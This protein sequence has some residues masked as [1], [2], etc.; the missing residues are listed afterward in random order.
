[1][2]Q[3]FCLGWIAGISL[4]GKTWGDLQ[5][6]L[7][8]VGCIAAVWLVLQRMMQP[9]LKDQHLALKIFNICM[10]I[11]LAGYLGF[12]YA[13][14]ALEQ[15]LSH[16]EHQPEDRDVIVYVE[17]LSELTEQGMQQKVT[18]LNQPNTASS[19]DQLQYLAYIPY[20]NLRSQQQELQLGQYYRLQGEL[21]PA[22]S[23]AIGGAFDQEKWYLQQRIASGFRVKHMEAL[24]EQHISALGYAK[25]IEQHQRWIHQVPLWI[26][27]QRLNFRIFLQHQPLPNKGL[28]LALLTGDESLLS[29]DTKMQFQQFGMSHLLAISGPHVVIFAMMVSWLLQRLIARF[30]PQQYLMIPK[31][32]ALMAPFLSCVFLY[33][34]FAGF[35]IPAVR[36]LLMCSLGCVIL[37]IQQKLQ[38]MKLLLLSAAI[39]LLIDPFS[40]LSAAFWLSYGACFILLRIYQTL[41]K[42]QLQLPQEV[43]WKKKLALSVQLLLESQWKIFAAL[44]PL[45]ILFFKQLAWITP[46]SNIIAIPWLGMLV[47]PLDIL[48]AMSYSISEPL[49]A[50]LFLLNDRLLALLLA[51]LN[52]LDFLFKPELSAI[53]MNQPMLALLAL[54]LLI[55][56]LPRRLLPKGWAVIGLLALCLKGFMPHP[57]ELTVLDV[58]QGQAIFIRDAKRSM[59]VDMGGNYDES[60]FSVGKQIILP[61]LAVNAVSEL[62]QLVLTH[63]DQDHSGGY[64]S[65]QNQLA[66]HQLISSERPESLPV[67]TQFDY[68]T[69]GQHWQWENQVSIEVLS[70]LRE[71]LQRQSQSKNENSCVLYVQIKQAAP[72]QSFLL[73]GDA[74]WET[75]FQLLQHYPNLHADVLVLGHHGSQHSSAY[76]FL[77]ALQPKLAIASAGRFNRYGHPSKL[78]QARL[79]QLNIPLLTTSQQGSIQFLQQDGKIRINFAR[80]EWK[81]LQKIKAQEPWPELR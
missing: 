21:R 62:D 6:S 70:P 59:M 48:A 19:D 23:Y 18:V 80:D 41:Q 47:V 58:G 12:G 55:A 33:C 37:L 4:I 75:E 57:F 39:L 40:I 15:R 65:I 29:K 16:I 9:L 3:W 25:V 67:Q 63:L 11:C 76:S 2:L 78:T 10:S 7:W 35:E 22:H 81:W 30:W 36:T 50:V 17:Q 56:F 60:K 79:K 74:G 53:A 14:H 64:F 24:T 66:I 44:C 71:P 46:L 13:N 38:P 28:L 51:F 54:S 26:E 5:F 1:M 69:Q 52:G 27:K 20:A 61:F 45:M 43:H 49:A 42:Q 8:S 72:Y 34:L 68:C 31:Q 73:M 32:Y 77:K